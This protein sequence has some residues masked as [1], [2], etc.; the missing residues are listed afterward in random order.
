MTD[1][2]IKNEQWYVI[3]LVAKI[4]KNDIVKPKFQRK[5]KWD[6]Y[7]RKENVPNEESYI[8]FLFETHNSV[9]AITFGDIMTS[10]SGFTNIDGNNRINAIMHFINKPFEIFPRYLTPL[11]T[12]LDKEC[13][14]KSCLDEVKN[15]FRQMSYRDIISIKTPDR[16]FRDI[17]RS[18]LY[19]QI[20]HI[21]TDIE[22]EVEEIQKKLQINGNEHFDTNVKINVNLFEGYST[23]ELC[24]IFQDINKFN[25][26]LTETELLACVLY[27]QNNFVITNPTINTEIT[28]QIKKDYQAKSEGEV[29]KCY[30]FEKTDAINGYDFVI[31]FQNLCNFKY[32]FI[33]RADYTGLSL[34]FKVYKMLYSLQYSFTTKNVNEFIEII[35]YCCETLQEVVQ[36]VFTDKINTNLFNK[37]CE[38][39]INNIRKNTLY[40]ILSALIGFYRKNTEKNIVKS[41]ISK[42]ILFHFIV[43][44]VSD[45]DKR[46]YFKTYDSIAYDAG[47]A[48]I[49]NITKKYLSHPESLCVKLTEE[50]YEDLIDHLCVENNC[51]YDR[52]L[53]KEQT[54][55][56]NDKRRKLSFWAKT[57]MFYY[58]K[59]NIPTNMLDNKFSIEH[60]VPNSSI[61]DGQL[62]KDRIG[63]MI[64]II[65]SMNCSRGNR[66]INHYVENDP[67]RF[68]YYIRNIIPSN[69]VYDN[70]VQHSDR[71]VKV[72]NNDAYDKLCE[73]NQSIYKSNFIKCLFKHKNSSHNVSAH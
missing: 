39:K 60:I 17:K 47:G 18:D 71:K 5:Q 46:D 35:H 15:I 10:K 14:N 28:E 54:K 21:N 27:T 30:L 31:G 32:K 42:C 16:Y 73:Q 23:D 62:D 41:E 4:M 63:N 68:C 58:Y 69:D 65:A 1:K 20:R 56:K 57:L 67:H 37:S 51:P 2:R 26:K 53:D 25:S 8:R 19:S 13:T 59:E 66:H 24:K 52:F 44:D 61:W 11:F 33:E 48:F 22:D 40:M 43:S 6:V 72:I 9:H 7:L 70:I 49:E 34:F 29:L 12:L 3:E 45:K 38:E 50:I 64:P 55:Y 36:D